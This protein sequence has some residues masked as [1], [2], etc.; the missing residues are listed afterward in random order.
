MNSFNEVK[1]LKD[2]N[3]INLN[4]KGESIYIV[5]EGKC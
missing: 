5:M 3:I 4:E 1:F 2:E